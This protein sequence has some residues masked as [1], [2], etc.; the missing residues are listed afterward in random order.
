MRDFKIKLISLPLLYFQEAYTQFFLPYSLGILTA[1]LKENNY[2]VIL[3]DLSIKIEDNN[4][5]FRFSS[6]SRINLNILRQERDIIDYSYNHSH[7]KK[8]GRFAEQITQIVSCASYDLIGISVVTYSNFLFA[9]LLSR[10]IKSINKTKIVLGGP[11]IT[12][13]GK[14]LFEEFP[15]VDYMISGDGQIPLLKLIEHLEGQLSIEEIPSLFYREN[16]TIKANPRKSFPIENLSIPDFSDLNLNLY[17]SMGDND[18][19][20]PYLVT[21]G[22][23]RN[24]NFCKH[25][26]VNSFFESKSYYK[27]VREL[28]TLKERYRTN[29]FWFRDDNINS[30]YE[31]LDRLCDIFIEERLDISW[32]AIAIA[33]NLNGRI[34][35]KMKKAG[36]KSLS[37]DIIS[38]SDRVLKS[39]NKGFGVERSSSVLMDSY[40]EGIKN[41][42]Y[43]TV[44]YPHEQEKDIT[45]TTEFIK[46]NSKYI[47]FIAAVV[48]FV[49]LY[50]TPLYD[51]P[52]LFGIKNLRPVSDNFPKF[53]FKHFAF[54]EIDGPKWEEKIRLQERFRKKILEADFKY[55]L[56]KKYHFNFIPFWFY[57]WLREKLRFLYVGWVFRII[58]LFLPYLGKKTKV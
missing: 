30:S 7:N 55:V 43:F 22:C 5:K 39:M 36:W 13:Y 44:G 41:I 8:V 42:I 47:D 23:R 16:G 27:V 28:K 20:L 46:I 3:D 52:E 26:A 10:E 12:I 51:N 45:Q 54:D 50:N 58:K 21:R 2:Q 25:K 9:L 38:G 37:F 57:F 33:D 17:R 53:V 19:V 34:L 24:C 4:K 6:N 35:H 48:P 1:F 18:L 29:S 11:F 32:R 15:V 14:E 31:Y 49:A 56:P 40:R